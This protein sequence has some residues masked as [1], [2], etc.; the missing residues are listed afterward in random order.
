[1]SYTLLNPHKGQGNVPESPGKK[2]L[3]VELQL[4]TFVY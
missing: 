3:S 2:N 1:M 4:N